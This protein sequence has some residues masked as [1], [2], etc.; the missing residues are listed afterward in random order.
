MRKF[1]LC[2]VA[3]LTVVTCFSACKKG[4][5]VSSSTTSES[6]S[7]ATSQSSGYVIE[8]TQNEVSV[9]VG[10]SIQLEVEVSKNNVYVFWS[11]RDENIATVTDDGVITALA[12]GQTICY[13]EFGGHTATCLIKVTA[14]QADPLLSVSVSHENGEATLCMG[15]YLDVNATV[16]LGDDVLSS[17]NVSYIIDVEGVVIISNGVIYAEDEGVAVITIVAEYQDQTVETQLV[18]TVLPA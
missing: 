9:V 3:L 10:E 17:A 12:E 18:I 7:V 8:F 5:G 2:I 13:A 4:G 6:E 11:V 14:K 16:K 1:I 15:D